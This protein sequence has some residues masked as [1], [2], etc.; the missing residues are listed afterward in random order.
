MALR[1]VEK[2]EERV[3]EVKEEDP[4]RAERML[5]GAAVSSSLLRAAGVKVQD[6]KKLLKKSM[7]RK[8]KSREKSAKAW[9]GR[10]KEVAKSVEAGIKEGKEKRFKAK[11][12][13]KARMASKLERDKAK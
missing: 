10:S 6:N 3:A 9:K 13:S 8:E 12:K 7:K 11:N 1:K 5:H 4:E 2:F